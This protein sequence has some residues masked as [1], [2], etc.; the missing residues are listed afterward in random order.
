MQMTAIV[1]IIAITVANDN[2][3]GINDHPDDP[4]EHEPD[5]GDGDEHSYHTRSRTR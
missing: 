2:D 5:D 1:M 3:D 4:N